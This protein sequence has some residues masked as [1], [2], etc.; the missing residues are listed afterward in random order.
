MCT[1]LNSKPISYFIDTIVKYQETC[2][3]GQNRKP[4]WIFQ[5]P[6]LANTTALTGSRVPKCYVNRLVML[7]QPRYS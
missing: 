5:N 3:I 2:F 6:V 1:K 4:K 7:R